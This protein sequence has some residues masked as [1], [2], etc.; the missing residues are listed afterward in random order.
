MTVT[1]DGYALLP[2][3]RGLPPGAPIRRCM[4]LL[5]TL[6]VATRRWRAVAR[7]A[8]EAVSIHRAHTNEGATNVTKTV[9]IDRNC[10]NLRR[11]LAEYAI[12]V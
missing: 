8:P 9:G 10:S 7:P 11:V 4:L 5:A 2:D 12:S 1:V 6:P 3:S